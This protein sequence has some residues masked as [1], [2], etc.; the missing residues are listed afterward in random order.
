MFCLDMFFDASLLRL[1]TDTIR[2]RGDSTIQASAKEDGRVL[3][4]TRHV[5]TV[6][7]DLS[8]IDRA[9]GAQV[10]KTRTRLTLSFSPLSCK[11]KLV[12]V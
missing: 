9:A 5:Y 7:S 12:A 4:L 2:N 11:A 6:C 1:Y 8:L 10:P 3:D